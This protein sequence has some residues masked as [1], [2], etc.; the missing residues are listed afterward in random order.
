MTD[1]IK[2][3]GRQAS[4][5]A[6]EEYHARQKTEFVGDVIYSD[7][8]DQKLADLII[9]EC[10]IALKPMLRDMISRGHAVDSIKSHFGGEE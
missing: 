4:K 10:S 2:A 5:L 1:R 8:Y 3:L 7:I 6:L 9:Q